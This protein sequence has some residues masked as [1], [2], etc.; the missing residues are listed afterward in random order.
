MT[1]QRELDHILGAFFVEG[2]NE[3]PDR[4]INAALEQIEHTPQRHAMRLPSRFRRMNMYARFAAAAVFGLFAVGGTLYLAGLPQ[5]PSG[6]PSPT[7]SARPSPGETV[8]AKPAV[9]VFTKGAGS[10]AEC[11]GATQGG[12]IS[13]LWV[14]NLDGTGAHELIPDQSGCQRFQA[15]SPDGTRLL[16][17][18]SDCRW[19]GG[20]AG[21]I[22][23]ERFYLTDASGSQPQLVDT[24][25]V[26]PCQADDHGVFS[27]DGRRIL[28]LR[29][30]IID[31][32]PSA[33]PDPV[34]GKPAQAMG[35]RVLASIDLP[36]G[37]VTE[38]GV[39]DQC[40]QCGSEW[41]RSDPRWSPDRT[42]IAFTW[43][44][45][46][47]GPNPGP[48][49]PGDLPVF[50]ADADGGNV[51]QL[52]PAGGIPSW[53]P[54]GTRIVFQI[55]RYEEVV[56]IFEYRL[57]QDIYT[58]RPDGTD[59]RRLTTDEISSNPGWSVDGRIWFIRTPRV[60][61]NQQTEG[62]YQYWVM[63]ADGSNAT[64]SSGP[65]QPQDLADAAMQPTP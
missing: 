28:F 2:T 56:P 61:G 39:F 10:A 9:F 1:D 40:D 25:C 32:P 20:E 52:S 41:P 51:H 13:R 50:I 18:R 8:Q 12:C 29:S 35:L 6:L 36:T 49:A 37:Q 7:P 54:D 46:I 34:T 23:V 21:M 43:A 58:I 14:A 53:S 65:P 45:P 62:P 30:K 55:D 27:S 42:Q 11:G 17:S 64:Q 19:G 5:P 63:D 57:F 15:W 16:F 24:G 44:V 3:L 60:D 48:Q 26:S 31:A 4:V 33:T 38:L 47:P 59:L 22:G